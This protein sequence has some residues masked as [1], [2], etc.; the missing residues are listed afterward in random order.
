M[1]K[2][3]EILDDIN[4]ENEDLKIVESSITREEKNRILE[5]TLNKA[6]V[7]GKK[8][9]GR[10]SILPLAAA[11]TLILSFAVVF[12]QGGLS[13]IYYK[14]FGENIKYVTEMGTVIDKS[15]SSNGITFNVANMLG[16]ENAFYI[17]F[18]LIKDNGESFKE[19]DYIEFDR[20]RLDFKSSGGYTWYQVEDDDKNDNKATFILSGNIK[21]KIFGDKLTLQATNITEYSIKKSEKF[22]PY[23]FLLNHSD[24]IKANLFKNIFI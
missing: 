7:K 21:K 10:R 17:I 20:L 23:D 5:M 24:Y 11:M 9:Y 4:I 8:S 6:D 3:H 19:S 16:D 22:D 1:K 15:Y 13:N 18:E 12:A 14:L 2:I